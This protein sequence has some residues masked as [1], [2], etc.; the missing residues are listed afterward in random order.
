M[1]PSRRREKCAHCSRQAKR[2]ILWAGGRAYCPTCESHV[3][4]GLEKIRENGKLAEIVGVY[5]YETGRKVT[6]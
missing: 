3:T 6:D 1:K 5:D 2:K 4:L